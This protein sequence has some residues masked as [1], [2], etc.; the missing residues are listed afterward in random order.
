MSTIPLFYESIQFRIDNDQDLIKSFGWLP[1]FR[2]LRSWQGLQVYPPP[3]GTMIT[4]CQLQFS[5]TISG[6]P[7]T[8]PHWYFRPS[9]ITTYLLIVAILILHFPLTE[10]KTPTQSVF[11]L[12]EIQTF[13]LS[14]SST[15]SVLSLSPYF[16]F[17]HYNRKCMNSRFSLP[18]RFTDIRVFIIVLISLHN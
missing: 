10:F 11:L 1:P 14:L 8:W 4:P 18:F 15:L 17:L 3:L 13:C 12:I 2:F 9:E 16:P 7:H 6:N 5:D